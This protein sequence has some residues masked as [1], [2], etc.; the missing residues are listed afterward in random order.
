MPIFFLSGALFPIQ[1]LPKTIGIIARINPL[2]YGVD[3][4]RGVL[5]NGA[6]F[7]LFNDFAILTLITIIVLFL[8]S[9][10]FLKIQI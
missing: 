4:L 8:G 1:G 10:L 9:Y 2:S 7:G 5:V 3:G 6:S